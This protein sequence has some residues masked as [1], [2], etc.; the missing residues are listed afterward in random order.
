M[1]SLALLVTTLQKLDGIFKDYRTGYHV[2]RMI[3]L[4]GI[5]TPCFF[6]QE[7]AKSTQPQSLIT[8]FLNSIH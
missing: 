6:E 8:M 5:Y 2:K 1:M 3:V 7:Q 4:L